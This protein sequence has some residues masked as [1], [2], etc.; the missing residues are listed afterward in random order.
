MKKTK[1]KKVKGGFVAFLAACLLTVNVAPAMAGGE[2]WW[3]PFIVEIVMEMARDNGGGA[4]K[5]PCWS[6]A[7]NTNE[8]F[9]VDCASCLRVA[10]KAKGVGYMCTRGNGSNGS[11]VQ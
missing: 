2:D 7:G 9:Y 4:D 5:I 8:E 1:T 6:K 10:G 11:N 3:V